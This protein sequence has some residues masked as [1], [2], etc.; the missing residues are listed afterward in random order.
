LTPATGARS[1]GHASSYHRGG[2]GQRRLRQ[3]LT[4]L[5][6]FPR[7]TDRRATKL[8]GKL[9]SFGPWKTPKGP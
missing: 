9:H 1:R 8:R 7:A 3:A 4:R 6:L 5:P 2:P